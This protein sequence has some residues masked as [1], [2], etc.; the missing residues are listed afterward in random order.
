VADRDV[1]KELS[2]VET[3]PTLPD[4]VTRVLAVLD[5]E[6]VEVGSVAEL[7]GQDPA[8]TGQI[9]RVSNSVMFNAI[10]FSTTSIH[11]AI[12]RIGLREVRNLV[13]SLG[14]VEAFTGIRHGFDFREFWRHSFSTAVAAGTVAQ[15]IPGLAG[16]GNPRDNPYFLAGLLHDVGTLLLSQHMGDE[17]GQL[18]ADVAE[19]GRPLH[20]LERER[21]GTDHQQAGAA[22]IRR[23]GLPLEIAAAAEYHHGVD[24]APEDG[25]DYVLVVAAADAVLGRH[26]RNSPAELEANAPHEEELDGLGV[27]EEDLVDMADAVMLAAQTS[28]ALLAV[29][30]P[31]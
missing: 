16:P 10:G 11:E 27:G 9:L 23:W 31:A 25:R 8:M 13:I 4:V 19:R 5:C 12:G 26:G 29:A 22:L 3:L 1:L 7:V 18:L 6:E 24:G 2:R 30:L 20:E 17:Y 15:R 21:L 14:V 28:D